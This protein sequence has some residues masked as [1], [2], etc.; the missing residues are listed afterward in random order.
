MWMQVIKFAKTT[1][2]MDRPGFVVKLDLLTFF[3][4]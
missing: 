2:S 4:Q 1:G 3:R